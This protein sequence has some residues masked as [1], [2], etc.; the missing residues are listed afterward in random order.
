MNVARACWLLDIAV[1]LPLADGS[2]NNTT[3]APNLVATKVRDQN[4]VTILIRLIER[5]KLS[6]DND[7]KTT[8][9]MWVRGGLARYHW[10]GPH[11]LN[12]VT[13]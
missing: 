6:A 3:E 2:T 13:I 4:L 11:E 8:N 9:L 12:L 1:D 10:T 5:R 7:R